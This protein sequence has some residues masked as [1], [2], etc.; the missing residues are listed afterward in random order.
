MDLYSNALLLFLVM[1]P[2][3]NM[4]VF[5]GVLEGVEPAR[6][7][8]VLVRE[9]FIALG[10]L[11]VFLFCGQVL[12]DALK[13]SREAMSIGGAIILFLIALKLIFQSGKNIFG[14]SIQGEPFVVPLAT[15]AVAGPSSL[16]VL[17]LLSKTYPEHTGT[18]LMVVGLAWIATAGILM[19]A[20]RLYRVLGDRGIMA[21]QRL[22]GMMLVMLSVQMML[23]AIHST[24]HLA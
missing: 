1:D 11:L 23:N 18:L 13:L 10:L 14:E 22:M 6:R 21:V 17:M 5:L 20:S 16:A 3:G 8:R 2:L 4:P 15:P 7:Q 24:F 12:L 9:L 19:C